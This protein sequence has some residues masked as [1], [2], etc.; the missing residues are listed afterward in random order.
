MPGQ[1]R[2]GT[3]SEEG[4]KGYAK[5]KVDFSQHATEKLTTK[6]QSRHK[7]HKEIIIILFG[8]SEIWRLGVVKEISQ[9]NIIF[10]EF[11]RP[12]SQ[13]SVGP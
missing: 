11:L 3:L 4:T 9:K 2:Y 12:L 7:V 13:I 5:C 1:P 8:H 6:A 10:P